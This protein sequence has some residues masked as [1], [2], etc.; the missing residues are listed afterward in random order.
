M[1]DCSLRGQPQLVRGSR[2]GRQSIRQNT[3]NDEQQKGAERQRDPLP[4][5]AQHRRIDR[6]KP[7]FV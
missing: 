6:F 4:P 3:H 2:P 1:G 5:T 7:L